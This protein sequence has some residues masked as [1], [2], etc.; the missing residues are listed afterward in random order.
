MAVL[1]QSMISS[2]SPPYSARG[3]SL[4]KTQLL[5]RI[6]SIYTDPHRRI[7]ICSLEVS[8]DV[9]GMFKTLPAH[10]GF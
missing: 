8:E 3:G 2:A 7:Y 1:D 4:Q 6:V 9:K 5:N 10:V